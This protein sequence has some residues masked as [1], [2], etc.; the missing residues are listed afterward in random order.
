MT[1]LKTLTPS[2]IPCGVPVCFR[3]YFWTSDLQQN[4]EFKL[5]QLSGVRVLCVDRGWSLNPPSFLLLPRITQKPFCRELGFWETECESHWFGPCLFL[6]GRESA[7]KDDVLSRIL[8][9][10]FPSS[11]ARIVPLWEKSHG[12]GGRAPS[13]C[14]GQPSW[15]RSSYLREE[16]FR[17]CGQPHTEFH[18]SLSA[19]LCL[20][21]VT[22]VEIWTGTLET[23][24]GHQISI[25]SHLIPSR[26]HLSFNRPVPAAPWLYPTIPYPPGL[27]VGV[28]FFHE[29]FKVS[30]SVVNKQLGIAD[31]V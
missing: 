9:M 30:P 15:Q 1:N 31:V 29:C 28:I 8:W 10:T 25:A 2:I 11:W 13:S 19:C 4:P 3:V 21:A 23:A 24:G 14:P 20:L 26:Q 16:F 7:D 12:V 17:K 6:T 27:E 18:V 5:T 22:D